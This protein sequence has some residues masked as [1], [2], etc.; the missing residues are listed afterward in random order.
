MRVLYTMGTNLTSN[1]NE[2]HL[3][4]YIA[5]L[6]FSVQGI[7][8]TPVITGRLKLVRSCCT[9]ESAQGHLEPFTKGNGTVRELHTQDMHFLQNVY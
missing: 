8:E 5:S 6:S 2:T 1:L 7:K 9:Q 4:L 3:S